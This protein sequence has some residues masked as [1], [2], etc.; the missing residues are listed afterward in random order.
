MR[1]KEI[2][3][4]LDQG[5]GQKRGR[6]GPQTGEGKMPKIAHIEKPVSRGQK[7][8]SWRKENERPELK[9]GAR[10]RKGGE[11][12]RGGEGERPSKRKKNHATLCGN[13]AAKKKNDVK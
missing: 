8:K 12:S 11:T 13:Q 9:R 6:T 10:E 4:T 3:G 2:L 5:G 1:G 7:A